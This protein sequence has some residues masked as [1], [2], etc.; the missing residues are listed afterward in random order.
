MKSTPIVIGSYY[1]VQEMGEHSL[2]I[3][4]LSYLFKDSHISKKKV[5][6]AP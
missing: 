3:F 6:F 2:A 1:D 4:I 5:N